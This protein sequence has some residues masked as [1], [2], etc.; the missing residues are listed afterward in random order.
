MHCLQP[1]FFFTGTYGLLVSFRFFWKERWIMAVT[2]A[3]FWGGFRDLP[4]RFSSLTSVLVSCISRFSHHIS[5]HLSVLEG[6]LIFTSCFAMSSLL[7]TFVFGLTT[8]DVCWTTLAFWDRSGRTGVFEGL[9]WLG[10]MD[11]LW[12]ISSVWLSG[13]K[14]QFLV[15]S[16]WLSG[17]TSY[18]ALIVKLL[19]NSIWFC[20]TTDEFS[21]STKTSGFISISGPSSLMSILK[22]FWLSSASF[23]PSN[24]ASRRRSFS[25][26]LGSLVKPTTFLSIITTFLVGVSLRVSKSCNRH[27]VPLLS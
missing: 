4:S 1:V 17:P 24:I 23:W 5:M 22:T 9:G 20:L 27:A 19:V 3:I 2:F 16:T 14:V 10:P 18:S 15:L 7:G 26:S 13:V 11:L 25:L 6:S 12:G 8:C 21:S